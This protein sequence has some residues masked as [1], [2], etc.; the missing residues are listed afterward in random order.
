VLEDRELIV[1][2]DR[3]GVPAADLARAR[4]IAVLLPLRW[5]AVGGAAAGIAL[6]LPIIGI[7]LVLAP[8]SLLIIA[9]TFAVGIALVLASLASSEP[10]V[11]SIRRA[12]A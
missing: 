5:A 1:G 9:G 10:L 2:L 12:A 4:R 6:S 11:R 3:L 7:T 8:T